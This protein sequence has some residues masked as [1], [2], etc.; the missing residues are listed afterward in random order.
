MEV[1]FELRVSLGKGVDL[2]SLSLILIGWRILERENLAGRKRAL[3]V[4]RISFIYQ[5]DKLPSSAKI[6]GIRVY[7][8]WNPDFFY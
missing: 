7:S 5:K 6:S 2:N 4:E 3:S 1:I 8:F